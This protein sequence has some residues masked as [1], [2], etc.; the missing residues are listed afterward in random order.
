MNDIENGLKTEK[1]KLNTKDVLLK[2]LRNGGVYLALLIL[3]IISSILE[4][5]SLELGHVLDILK[6]TSV[7]GIVV[8]AQTLLI[9]TRG[10]DLS[11]GAHLILIT[12]IIDGISM[13][14]PGRTVLVIILSLVVG[15]LV[16]LIN[17]LLVVKL[18]IEPLVSSLGVMTLITGISFIYTKGFAKGKAPP[19]VNILGGSELFGFL[20]VSVII[21]AVLAIISIFVLKRTVF[22]RFIYAIGANPKAASIAGIKVDKVAILIYVISGLL[23]AF[24]GIVWAGYIG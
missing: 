9:I 10:I 1:S 6:N 5:R 18:K 14:V 7:L 22:G 13:G 16:G 12:L 21:W 20:P 2:I 24:A 4:P 11:V 19:F 17:G 8:I 23:V 15:A 3:I